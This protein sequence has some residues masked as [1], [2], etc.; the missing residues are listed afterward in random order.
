MLER[1]MQPRLRADIKDILGQVSTHLAKARLG[2]S[3]LP[4]LAATAAG[5]AQADLNALASRDAAALSNPEYVYATYL[6][7]RAVLAYRTAHLVYQLRP[8]RTG[9]QWAVRSAARRITELAKA[10]T[11][12]EIHPAATIGARFVLDHGS[13]TVIGAEVEIGQDC[14]ILQNVTLGGRSIGHSN[15]LVGSPRHPRIGDRVEIGANAMVLGPVTVGDDCRLDPGAR[16]T[17]DI[18]PRSRV[19]V[20]ATLQV[21]V[22]DSFPEI[23]GFAALPGELLICGHGLTDCLPVLVDSERELISVLPIHSHDDVHIRCKITND[24]YAASSIGLMYDNDIVS[25]IIFKDCYKCRPS[26]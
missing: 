20:I 26:T 23:H 11:G 12:I 6:S 18:P 8:A 19:R 10:A 15:L 24:E 14:Y 13:G 17:T 22:A 2:R 7:F 21:T 16:V 1:P 9:G 5:Q 4:D 3:A 25:Y